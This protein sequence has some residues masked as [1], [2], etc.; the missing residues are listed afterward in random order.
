MNYKELLLDLTNCNIDK[1]NWLDVWRY[2]R[3]I[4]P[5]KAHVRI[6]GFNVFVNVYSETDFDVEIN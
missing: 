5:L 6:K 4:K 3:S 1:L 2:K